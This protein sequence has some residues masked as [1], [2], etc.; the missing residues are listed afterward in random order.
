[1]ATGTWAQLNAKDRS[2]P[3]KSLKLGRQTRA[4]EWRSL[5]GLLVAMDALMIG[6]S[7]RFAYD[8]RIGSGLIEYGAEYSPEAYTAVALAAI[9]MWLGLFALLGM[10]RRDNLLGG[11][12]EYQQAVKGCTAGIIALIVL[13]FFSR[14]TV[15]VSRLWLALSWIL[16]V[17]FVLTARFFARRLGYKL[18]E[19]GYLTARVVIVGAN[20]QGI[21]IADQWLRSPAS[22]MN[23]VGFVDDFKS[24]GTP[25]VGGIPVVGQPSALP[26]IAQRLRVD[27]VV[28]VLN[29]V[30]WES[31]EELIG[32]A[33]RAKRYTLRL[34]PGFYELLTTGVAV[35][36]KTF[37][38]LFSINEGRIVGPDRV[39]KTMLDYGLGGL[40][41][42]LMAPVGL[43]AALLLALQKRTLRVGAA[44]KTIGQGGQ[45]FT[46]YKLAVRNPDAEANVSRLEQAIYRAGLDKLPQLINVLKGQMSLVGPRPRVI[47]GGES[48]PST[49]NNLSAVKPGIVGAWSV[50]ET[51]TSADEI[52]NDLYYVRNWTIWF[53]AQILLQTALSLAGLGRRAQPEPE[54]VGLSNAAP[55]A[56]AY[57]EE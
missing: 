9:P 18:R 43:A 5:I 49:R 42:V 1:M 34:S 21:A 26:E 10:Y 3:V 38:P 55:R 29:A 20:S 36:N 56:T 46:M 33:S 23:V 22:G 19:H 24:V 13:S 11:L 35:T 52:S 15:L 27:E 12:V 51:W 40:L 25:I 4:R 8:L 45:P 54:A 14:E 30:A 44:Y 47:G 28:V 31:F 37:V 53:D 16:S 41:A 32:Q 39:M 50:S 57:S 48:D 17:S 2:A 7:L 6:L